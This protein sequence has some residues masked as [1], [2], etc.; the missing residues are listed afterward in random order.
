[1]S[2]NVLSF[3]PDNPSV[4]QRDQMGRIGTRKHQHVQIVDRVLH[5]VLD[6]DASA[7]IGRRLGPVEIIEWSILQPSGHRF[8]TARRKQGIGIDE[9][10]VPTLSKKVLSQS[11][12]FRIGE[13]RIRVRVGRCCPAY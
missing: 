11:I 2:E 3:D 1:M 12:E 5:D 4:R 6:T 8:H 7:D 13:A 10:L 9:C